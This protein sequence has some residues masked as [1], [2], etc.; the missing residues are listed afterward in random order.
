M[1]LNLNYIKKFLFGTSKQNL[2]NLINNFLLESSDCTNK[3]EFVKILLSKINE[4]LEISCGTVFLLDKKIEGYKFIDSY[5]LNSDIVNNIVFS[6]EDDLLKYLGSS[7]VFLYKN[8]YMEL[9]D[10]TQ[11]KL[12]KLKA[13]ICIPMVVKERLIGLL[14]LGEK[15]DKKKYSNL[16]IEFLQQIST[17]A[18]ILVENMFLYREVFNQ[19]QELENAYN[20]LQQYVQIVETDK[21]ILQEAY[22]EITQTLVETLEARDAYT[23]GH[24]ERVTLYSCAIAREL[25]LNEDEIRI[26]ALGSS[27]HD[28]GKIGT[29]DHILLKKSS[30]TDEEYNEMR[31]HA[32]IGANI[33]S[34]L[35]FLTDIVPMIRGHHERYDGKGYPDGLSGKNIPIGA[36]I[37]C[38]TDSY[39]AMTSNRP[40]RRNIGKEK[41]ISILKEGSGTQ[42]DPE[43]VETFLRILDKI[44]IPEYLLQY[45]SNEETPISNLK[46]FESKTITGSQISISNTS[47][48]HTGQINI[49][50]NLGKE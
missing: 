10:K 9:S 41:A 17:N 44:E 12:N 29:R 8:K 46:A 5:G 20:Q 27:L 38:V 6:W 22:I 40:Y 15:K 48:H 50:Q 30:L 39:D 26:I 36:R 1:L 16:E 3:D 4:G 19:M 14:I 34:S 18:T 31:R 2:Q 35:K 42:F 45:G 37:L 24:S 49:T 21:E 33:L 11:E 43:I 13:H 47:L 7:E 32:L 28:I 23:R 25:G